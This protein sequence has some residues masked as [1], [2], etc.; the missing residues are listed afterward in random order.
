[1]LRLNLDGNWEPEDFIEVLRG[2]ES[3]YYKAAIERSYRHQGSMGWIGPWRSATFE[4]Y[5]EEANGWFLSEA[6]AIA[7]PHERLRIASVEYG[8]PGSIDL[9]GVGKVCEVL[10]N[11]V[12]RSVTYFDERDLRR[13]RNRQAKLETR[14][15]EIELEGEEE[16]V[17]AL[18]LANAQKLLEIRRDFPDWTEDHFL[19]LAVS[20]QDK[21]LPRISEGKLVGA[22]SLE[23]E[24]PRGDKAA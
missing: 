2:V 11:V 24:P 23:D 18:K 14:R 5:V 1:M 21:I 15:K 9:L 4:G 6:R 8:S 20:D 10:A 3:L 19:L 22:K 12:G 13:E 17:R 16:G 7:L